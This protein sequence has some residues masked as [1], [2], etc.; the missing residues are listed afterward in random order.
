M[1]TIINK[2]KIDEITQFN[3]CCDLLEYMKSFNQD[4]YLYGCFTE[5]IVESN[6]IITIKDTNLRFSF[7]IIGLNQ[8]EIEYFKLRYTS[9]N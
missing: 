2:L 5:C 6:S 9:N 8:L 3:N 7:Y 4:I 1:Y